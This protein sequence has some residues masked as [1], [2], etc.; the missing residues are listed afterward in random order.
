MVR[1][2]E[3]GP[4]QAAD[5]APLPRTPGFPAVRLG[6]H[7]FFYSPRR[8]RGPEPERLKINRDDDD[9]EDAV[10]EALEQQRPE[11]SADEE[12]ENGEPED[13]G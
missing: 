7:L 10:R 6:S 4:R 13:D 12:E 2:R 9:W 5:C 11:G 8:R 1:W 3:G